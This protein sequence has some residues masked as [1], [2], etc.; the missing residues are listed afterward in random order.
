MDQRP[1]N[2]NKTGGVI[3]KC[4]ITIDPG[5]SGAVAISY[6]GKVYAE[7]CPDNE[8]EM[9]EILSDAIRESK[10]CF[11]LIEKV[12]AMPGNGSVSM[13]SFG[14]NYGAWL[15]ILSALQIPYQTVTPQK[16]QKAVGCMPKDKKARKNRIKAYSAALYP[17]V[18]VTLANADA[19]AMLSVIDK[20]R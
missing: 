1:T 20:V 19:L 16:W 18:K 14:R 15:G 9:T 2:Q 3:M 7:N 13:F 5:K 4:L 8:A 11:C 12:G 10:D 6:N 17:H